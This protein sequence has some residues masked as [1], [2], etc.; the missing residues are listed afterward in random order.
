VYGARSRFPGNG[1]DRQDTQHKTD[2]LATSIWGGSRDMLNKSH[3]VTNIASAAAILKAIIESVL[4]S[5]AVA[6]LFCTGTLLLT[7][8]LHTS[9]LSKATAQTLTPAYIKKYPTTAKY[10]KCSSNRSIA[11]QG[12]FR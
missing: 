12:G 6:L 9:S 4:A 1:E 11:E 3:L 5:L 10:L 2:A 7:G 8:Y